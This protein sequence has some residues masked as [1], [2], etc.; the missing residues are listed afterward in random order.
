MDMNQLTKIT[1]SWELYEQTVTKTIIAQRLEV[2]RETV[3]IW[4]RGILNNPLGLTGF[5]DPYLNAK[6]GERRKRK[7]DG[8]L[9]AYIYRIRKNKDCCGQKIKNT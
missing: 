7:I 2:N 8:L 6:K 5:I 4:T 3:R 9:K 1:L